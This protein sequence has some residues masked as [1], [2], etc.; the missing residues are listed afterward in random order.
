MKAAVMGCGWEDVP[1][2]PKYGKHPGPDV[3]EYMNSPTPE[4]PCY[5]F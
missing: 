3:L 2:E 1:I 5:L 4:P